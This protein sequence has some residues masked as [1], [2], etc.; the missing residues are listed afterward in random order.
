[1]MAATIGTIGTLDCYIGCADK[2]P[3]AGRYSVRNLRL[4]DST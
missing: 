2:A 1:M 3:T 4:E